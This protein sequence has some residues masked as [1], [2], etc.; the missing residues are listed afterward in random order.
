MEGLGRVRTKE[1]KLAEKRSYDDWRKEVDKEILRLTDN[2]LVGDDLPD[3]GYWDA[4]DEGVTP[5][6]AA[7]SVLSEAS[8]F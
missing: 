2:L 8:F 3:W 4:W 7:K 6:Q 1:T 5:R